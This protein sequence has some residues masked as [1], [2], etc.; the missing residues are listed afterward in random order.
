M[1]KL[2]IVIMGFSF[3]ATVFFQ[4]SIPVKGSLPIPLACL[5]LPR[6]CS[7]GVGCLWE[8]VGP[9][10]KTSFFPQ[11]CDLLRDNRKDS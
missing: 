3:E 5:S 7:G 2:Q 4:R 11:G 1:Y 6:V 8:W 10:S 9:V